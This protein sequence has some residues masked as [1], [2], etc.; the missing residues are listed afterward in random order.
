MPGKQP[1]PQHGSL[2]SSS[3]IKEGSIQLIGLGKGSA[4]AVAMMVPMVR[5]MKDL[6][7]I[8]VEEEVMS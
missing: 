4:T 7:L 6:M 1:K 5:I 8:S 2:Q 3:G